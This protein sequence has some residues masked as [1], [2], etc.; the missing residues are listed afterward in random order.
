MTAI[1]FMKA[2]IRIAQCSLN[3]FTLVE[4]LAAV[5]ILSIAIV[6]PI[7]LI[8]NSIHKIYYARDQVVAISLAQEG[9][10][11]VRQVR[12]SNMLSGGPWDTG[13]SNGTYTIDAGRFVSVALPATSNFIIPC[14][15]CTTPQPVFIDMSAVGANSTNG[16]YRQSVSGPTSL[17]QFSRIVTIEPVTS[18]EIKV[19]SKVEWK[20]GGETGTI[21]ISEYLFNLI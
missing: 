17:T 3:G 9:I 16:L 15:G 6:G 2:K 19:S 12:D 18:D 20:T 1:K 21:N 10:E 7:H 5:T 8:G 4:T 13:I 11:M 14:V